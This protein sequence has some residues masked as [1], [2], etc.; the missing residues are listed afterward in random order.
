MATTTELNMH[1]LLLVMKN[2]EIKPNYHALATE[3]G[4]NS[5]NNA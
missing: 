3:A 4:I 5:A 1:Y 2:A